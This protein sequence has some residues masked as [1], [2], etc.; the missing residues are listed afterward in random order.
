MEHRPAPV[1]HPPSPGPS[2]ADG[3]GHARRHNDPDVVWAAVIIAVDKETHRAC[4]QSGPDIAQNHFGAALHEK[5]HVPL[6]LVV[7]PQRIIRR[8]GHEQAPQ[9]F[10][11][12]RTGRD[13]RRMNMKT[14]GAAAKHAR[15]R[16]L[17]RPKSNLRDNSLIAPDKFTEKPAMALRMDFPRKDFHAWNPD[18]LRIRLPTVD[19]GQLASIDSALRETLRRRP[20]LIIARSESALRGI[21][22]SSPQIFLIHVKSGQL[23][24]EKSARVRE[25]FG[26]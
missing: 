5:H 4:R 15:R 9:P 18:L 10:L 6:L 13:A 26:L 7:A 24:K 2:H 3:V 12:G 11:C 23:P 1:I 14:F 20:R 19:P 16:P 8:L 25:R 17:R 21:T 22:Q